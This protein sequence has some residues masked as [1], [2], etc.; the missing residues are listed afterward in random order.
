MVG[1]LF[2]YAADEPQAWA[3]IV[4]HLDKPEVG[5]PLRELRER[6]GSA[7]ADLMLAHRRA[8]PALTPE[9]LAVNEHRVRLLV[10]LLYGSLFSLVSWW[11]EHPE[12]SRRSA[13]AIAVEF[14]WLGLDRIR[15]G[16]RLP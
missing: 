8:D 11:L 13:E 14:I 12:T 9:A 4:R 2:D 10:P 3:L 16:E 15:A 7:F 5:A 1:V 6:L